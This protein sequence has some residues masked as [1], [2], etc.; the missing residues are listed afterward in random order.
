[1]QAAVEGV[2]QASKSVFESQLIDFVHG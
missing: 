2:R 1:V